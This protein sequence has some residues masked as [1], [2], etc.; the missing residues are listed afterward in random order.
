MDMSD[1]ENLEKHELLS[2][3]IDDQL[4]PR[5]ATELKRLLNNNPQIEAELKALEQQRN[6]LRAMPKESAPE[7]MAQDIKTALERRFILDH[8]CRHHDSAG[9]WGLVFRR[10]A[11]TAAM[12]LIPMGMLGIVVYSIVRQPQGARDSMPPISPIPPIAA[13]DPKPVPLPDEGAALYSALLQFQ[14]RHPVQSRDFIEKKI[15][16]LGLMDMTQIRPLSDRTSYKITA[17]RQYVVGLIKDLQELWPQAE[18]ATYALLP[19]QGRE[20]V[21]VEGIDLKQTVDMLNLT[22]IKKAAQLARTF[23]EQNNQRNLSANPDGSPLDNPSQPILAWDVPPTEIEQD[24]SDTICLV[25][26]VLGL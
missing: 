1:K 23:T 5:Q 15:H 22:D 24:A 17:S 16:T 8:N 26:E 18:K 11:A 12:V 10:L 13:N 9:R 25:I 20:A 4:S 21:L 2:G 6:L 19:G 14:T 3:Y 7:G